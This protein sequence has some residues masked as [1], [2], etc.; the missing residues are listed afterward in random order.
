MKTRIKLIVLICM[1][2]TAAWAQEESEPETVR[3]PE[4]FVTNWTK[5]P[6]QVTVTDPKAIVRDFARAVCS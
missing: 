6:L 4:T 3:N 1:F 5:T 2:T